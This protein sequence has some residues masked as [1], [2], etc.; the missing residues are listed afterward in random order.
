MAQALASMEAM[1]TR[2]LQTKTFDEL[3]GME[4]KAAADYFGVFRQ[5]LVNRMGFERREYYPPPD[6]LNALLR[7]VTRCCCVRQRA[8]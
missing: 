2:A 6:P 3:R 7:L 4:G 8:R 5:L 1:Q